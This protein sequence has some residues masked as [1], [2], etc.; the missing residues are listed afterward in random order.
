MAYLELLEGYKIAG[1][2]NMELA[3]QRVGPFRV[4]ERIGKLAYRLELPPPWKTWHI[5]S[6]AQLEPATK[7]QDPYRG[8]WVEKDQC[9]PCAFSFLSSVPLKALMVKRDARSDAWL[10]RG[11]VR[12]LFL[13]FLDKDDFSV[14]AV[15]TPSPASR[16]SLPPGLSPSPELRSPALPSVPALEQPLVSA[17]SVVLNMHLR[18]PLFIT[19]SKPLSIGNHMLRGIPL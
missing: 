9:G 14:G 10:A 12:S 5:V 2:S 7:G 15:R 4:I 17:P 11:P 8:R 18:C 6:I 1:L 3:L 13:S 19:R 16:H